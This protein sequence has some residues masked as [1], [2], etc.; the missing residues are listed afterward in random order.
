MRRGERTCDAL[1][2]PS[3][4]YLVSCV[5]SDHL[6]L[7]FALFCLPASRYGVIT[8]CA[9]FPLR[10]AVTPTGGQSSTSQSACFH[11]FSSRA[12]TITG[13]SHALFSP[14]FTTRPAQHS[15]VAYLHSG[16]NA[17]SL[18]VFFAHCPLHSEMVKISRSIVRCN[19]G[20]E[21]ITLWPRAMLR[22]VTVVTGGLASSIGTRE[23]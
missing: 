1:S 4:V 15:S 14:K 8:R 6:Q 3:L 16:S 11:G 10:A 12:L 20:V 7:H 23:G 18:G 22:L 17:F 21:V 19:Y 5:F 9:I 13:F 2:P